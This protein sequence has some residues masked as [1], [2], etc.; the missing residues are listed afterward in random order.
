MEG[1]SLKMQMPPLGVVDY[2]L[3]RLDWD[4]RFSYVSHK[5]R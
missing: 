4:W 2:E 5:W 3:A 1:E